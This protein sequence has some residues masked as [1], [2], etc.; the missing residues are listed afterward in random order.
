MEAT[1]M[2]TLSNQAFEDMTHSML[3]SYFWAGLSILILL[4]LLTRKAGL[5]LLAMILPNVLPVCMV[6]AL[7]HLLAIPLDMF[8]MLIGSI[9]IGLIV[10]DTIHLLYSFQRNVKEGLAPIDAM[11]NSLLTTGK[12][13]VATTVVLS[14]AFLIYCLSSLSNLMAFG[15]LTALCIMFAL[16]A[17]LLLL[18]AIL[19]L[20]YKNNKDLT[21]V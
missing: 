15:Y 4:M 6:L 14:F 16:V 13:L 10:D 21:Y 12:A 20:L 17:D 19:L 18:P 9:A 2:A 3:E 7:M 8:T 11:I 5:G 1:G